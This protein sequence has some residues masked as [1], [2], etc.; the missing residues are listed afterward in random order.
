LDIFRGF[1]FE[2]LPSESRKTL[3]ERKARRPE[4]GRT[5]FEVVHRWK[6][7]GWDLVLEQLLA[8]GAVKWDQRKLIVPE[9]PTPKRAEVL[10]SQSGSPPRAGGAR[11]VALLLLA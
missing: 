8:E 10:V 5:C 9:T 6:T 3:L 2:A 7:E 11:T 4:L 1:F